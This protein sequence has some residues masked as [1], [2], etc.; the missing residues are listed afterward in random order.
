MPPPSWGYALRTLPPAR[1][2]NYFNETMDKLKYTR[3]HTAC[4]LRV[5]EPSVAALQESLLRGPLEES[6]DPLRSPGVP[7]LG[8]SCRRARTV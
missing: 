5:L 7:G 8:T 6:R 4:F 2:P 3:M 1:Y